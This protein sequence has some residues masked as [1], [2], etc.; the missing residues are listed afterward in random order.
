D[1]S[2]SFDL[3]SLEIA[4]NFLKQQNQHPEKILILSDLPEEEGQEEESY[5]HLA[6][7]INNAGI[8]RLIGIGPRLLAYQGLFPANSIYFASTDTFVQALPDI[9]YSNAAALL[10]GA[11]RFAVE[12]ISKRLTMRA[13]D[14]A[15]H[16]NPNALEHSVKYYQSRLP[17]TTKL[18]VRVK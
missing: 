4:L 12:A 16:T 15:L 18:M 6:Q 1:D 10:Q 7:R 9:D 8:N 14:T 2:Y 5:L 11:R 17:E 13:L 3:A